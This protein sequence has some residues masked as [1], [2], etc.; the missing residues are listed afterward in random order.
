M[1]K[2]RNERPGYGKILDAWTPPEDAGE[3]VGCL[4]TSFTFSPVLFE[5]ECLGRFLQLESDAREDGPVYLVEREEKLAQLICAAALVDQHHACGVRSLRWDLLPARLPRGILHAKVSLLLWSR[6][7]RLI[8]ASANLSEDGYRRNHEVFGVLDY[9]AG[10]TLPLTVLAELLAF[11]REAVRTAVVSAAHLSPG[12]QRCEALLDRVARD[13]RAWG[14]SELPRS[15]ASPR[16][17]AVATGPARD[18]ALTTLSKQWP[19]SS[20]PDWAVVVSPFFD[21][22]EATNAPARA[23]WSL[24]RQRGVATVEYHLTAEEVPGEAAVLLHAPESLLAAQPASRA[25]TETVIRRLKLEDGRPLHA[26]SLWLE[27]DAVALLLIGSSNFTSAGLG[28]GETQNLEANLA[29]AVGWQ[30][31]G[32]VQALEN[33]CLPAEEIPADCEWRWLPRTEADEDCAPASV[34]VLPLAFGE[35]N[36]GRD[37]SSR[38]FVELTFG[39]TPPTGWL[40]CVED[41]RETFLT[42]AD[43]YAQGAPPQFRVAW[44]RERPPSGFRVT[45][46]GAEG[47]AWWPV[48]VLSAAALPPP[49]ELR[50]LPLDVLIEILTSARPLHQALQRWLRQQQERQ[51][52]G[53]VITLDPHKRVDTSGF[54]LQRTRRVSDALRALRL[55]LERPV[56]SEQALAW[57]LRGPVGVLALAQALGKEAHT[58]AER[59]FLLT[60]LCLEL[61]RVRIAT[62]PGSLPAKQVRVALDELVDEIRT[63]I[64]LEALAG[65]PALATY[66]QA[67]FAGREQA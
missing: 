48:N 24:L 42:E 55:R 41:E 52:V 31:E 59:C 37:E 6:R 50:D 40:L 35:A 26:K 2:A 34:V 47:A 66:V 11:L 4:A 19:G 32:A 23:L 29:Y 7:A 12:V 64:S 8:V 67:A 36:F 60:E 16:V 20:P 54:L 45:W 27:N 61:G 5:E 57:R 62:A 44:E 46:T 51:Q 25:G 15:L 1:R 49:V 63:S 3:P 10:S 18:S 13:S 38:E 22:P 14:A 43:W 9:F 39:G 58:D 17:F 30:N 56:V 28:L 33:A 65:L 21:P 53:A